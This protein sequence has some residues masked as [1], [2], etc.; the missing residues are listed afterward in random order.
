MDMIPI[1]DREQL[2]AVLCSSGDPWTW[3][4]DGEV[5][6]SLEKDGIGYVRLLTHNHNLI[7]SD[8]EI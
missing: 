3:G 1:N 8:A 6:F 7:R 2:L 4:S 5:S